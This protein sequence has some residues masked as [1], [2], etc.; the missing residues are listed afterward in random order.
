MDILCLCIYVSFR[1]LSCVIMDRLLYALKFVHT[2]RKEFE[3]MQGF[4]PPTAETF[5]PSKVGSPPTHPRR[6]DVPIPPTT[7]P[8]QKRQTATLPGRGTSFSRDKHSVINQ[9]LPPIPSLHNQTNSG[10]RVSVTSDDSGIGAS[11]EGEI[12]RNKNRMGSSSVPA[13]GD[14]TFR[15]H[16]GPVSPKSQSDGG[17]FN[18][19]QV[20]QV[21]E[22]GD[23]EE[24]ENYRWFWGSMSRRDC[25]DRLRVEGEVGNFVVR[26]NATGNYVMSFW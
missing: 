15:R 17:K 16:L 12:R 1:C 6:Y 8:A 5:D 18:V 7:P 23:P 19:R 3:N 20:V 2:Q 21:E 9:P 11:N 22:V 4:T 14:G 10:R 24:L 26:I 13:S 25:E